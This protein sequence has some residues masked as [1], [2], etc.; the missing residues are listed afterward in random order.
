[1]THCKMSRQNFLR[2]NY[3]ETADVE[4]KSPSQSSIVGLSA[5]IGNRHT[6]MMYEAQTR[7]FVSV[8]PLWLFH[9]GTEKAPKYIRYIIIQ[10]Q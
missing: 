6:T 1:M 3:N 7:I 2:G 5:M 9:R 4:R 10:T 8:G